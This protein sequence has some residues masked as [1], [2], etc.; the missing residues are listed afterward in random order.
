MKQLK[1]SELKN[2]VPLEQLLV[3]L[4]KQSSHNK[5]DKDVF[6]TFLR[7]NYSTMFVDEIRRIFKQFEAGQFVADTTDAYNFNEWFARVISGYRSFKSTQEKEVYKTDRDFFPELY[8]KMKDESIRLGVVQFRPDIAVYG[9]EMFKMR[10]EIKN[11]DVENTPEY[12]KL[13]GAFLKQKKDNGARSYNLD[14]PLNLEAYK[15]HVKIY[16]F[17]KCFKK[18]YGL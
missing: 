5:P 1:I 8:E 13:R 11:V 12:H 14:Y 15:R 10:G 2:T 17:E 6:V 16:L 3:D 7:T 18:M 9:Y 4:L